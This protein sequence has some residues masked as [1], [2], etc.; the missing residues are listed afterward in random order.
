MRHSFELTVPTDVVEDA[1]DELSEGVRITIESSVKMWREKRMSASELEELL[2]SVSWQSPTLKGYFEDRTP[3]RGASDEEEPFEVI[4]AEDML[5]LMG[6]AESKHTRKKARFEYEAHDPQ[7]VSTTPL[8]TEIVHAAAAAAAPAQGPVKGMP[9][10]NS[11]QARSFRDLS[12]SR[13]S[14]EVGAFGCA[15]FDLTFAFGTLGHSKSLQELA[16]SCSDSDEDEAA[17]EPKPK[18]VHSASACEISR[19]ETA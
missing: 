9:S 13:M 12:L 8:Q 4:S 10:K 2:H 16:C 6:G 11:I 3:R 1:M 7:A 19:K 18:L 14:E 15:D 17:L 5:A